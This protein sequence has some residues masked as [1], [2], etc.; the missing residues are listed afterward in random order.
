[1]L[2]AGVVAIDIVAC[3]NRLGEGLL[4]QTGLTKTT[5]RDPNQGSS[6]SKRNFRV[7]ARDEKE[8]FP[9]VQ[10]FS[11]IFVIFLHRAPRACF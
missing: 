4:S 10:A 6:K 8:L 2:I 9:A 11:C 7:H 1:V 3:G 5:E